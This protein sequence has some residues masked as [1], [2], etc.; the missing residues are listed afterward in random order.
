MKYH[1]E[2]VIT[3]NLFSVGKSFLLTRMPRYEWPR[4]PFVAEVQ[5]QCHCRV[6]CN[7]IS[8]LLPNNSAFSEL[9]ILHIFFTKTDSYFGPSLAIIPL[10]V[11]NTPA[12]F[13]CAPVTEHA[14]FKHSPCTY[15]ELNM[16]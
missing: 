14:L 9:E 15:C 13:F 2:T 5:E 7:K 16:Y 3:Y 8:K 4:M 11:P 1:R 10:M 6:L 12:Y